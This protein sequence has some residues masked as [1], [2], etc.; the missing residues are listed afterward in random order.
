MKKI[1]VFV[2][3]LVASF[4]LSACVNI[5]TVDYYD[6]SDKY[7]I[8]SQEYEGTLD[9]LDIDWV[10]GYVKLIEDENATKIT[11]KEENELPDTIKVHS[12]FT[13]GKL[14]IKF[15]EAGY[16]GSGIK[17]KEKSL[18]ITYKSLNNINIKLTSGQFS[19]DKVNAKDAKINLTS[20]SIKVKSLNADST[21][22]K[23]TSGKIVFDKF[24]S[25]TAQIKMTSGSMAVDEL[26][27][28]SIN[29]SLTSGSCSFN[30]KACKNAE[31]RE[32]SGSINLTIPE[33]IA[34]KLILN[35]SNK[36]IRTDRTFTR[37]GNEYI[38]GPMDLDVSST[39]TISVTS[40]SVR[41]K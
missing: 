15:G 27:C 22:I 10:F 25:T 17:S 1:I 6:D 5:F 16:K 24:T 7:L 34:T 29:C 36:S 32:T 23:L 41:I 12:Y 8:G 21:S 28:D 39:I 11:I 3:L 13:D 38:F 26:T 14:Y 18:E 31:F 2:F 9:S 4:M 20:G 19:A 37:I 30:L 40:G 33:D 35:K